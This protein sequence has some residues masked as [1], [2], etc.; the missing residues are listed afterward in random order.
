MIELDKPKNDR[1][2]RELYTPKEVVGIIQRC[3]ND[4][5][6]MCKLTRGEV[7]LLWEFSNW[8]VGEF[9]DDKV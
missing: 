1:I 6:G 5:N 8:L 7:L 2:I 3:F 4:Y 9:K